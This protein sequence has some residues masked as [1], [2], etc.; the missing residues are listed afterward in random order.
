E[1]VAEDGSMM[2]LPGLQELG[3]RDG[4]PVIT[5]EQL[6]AYLNETE[7]IDAAA[8]AHGQQKRRVSLRA[9]AHVPT[10]HG[11][12]RFLAYKDRVTGTDHL[13]V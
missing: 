7:P 11:E 4:I 10:S 12:F 1:V 2:R 13:A 6:I 5:I 8:Q 3:E 9:E